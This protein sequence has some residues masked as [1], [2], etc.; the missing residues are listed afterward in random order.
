MFAGADLTREKL[1]TAL[2][3]MKD[4]DL[5]FGPEFKVRYSTDDHKAFNQVELTAVD[6]GGIEPLASLAFLKKQ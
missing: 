6:G 1:V 2:E 3:S 4:V 5:G